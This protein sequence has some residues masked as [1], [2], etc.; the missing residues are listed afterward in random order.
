MKLVLASTSPYRSQ[1]LRGV[2]L[3]FEVVPH[4]LDES[5]IA[6]EVQ[7]RARAL[8]L[9]KAQS[10]RG[11]H[12]DSHILGSDQLVVVEGEVLG[13]PGTREA[14][15]GQL[16]R[17]AGRHHQLL[18]AAVVLPPKGEPV[19]VLDVHTMHMRSL[20]DDEIDRYLSLDQ[21]LDCAGSYKIEAGGIA[22]FEKIEG[23][24]FTAIQGL[25]MVAV[26]SMLRTLGFRV[27]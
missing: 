22:L 3:Q 2:G 16:R 9:A 11:D 19:E 23:E 1:L 20:T 24:D 8:A 27:P 13:K 26:T 7:S 15:F 6:G 25:P 18:T 17:L 21:P 10:V 5:S 12:P 4:R 14:A